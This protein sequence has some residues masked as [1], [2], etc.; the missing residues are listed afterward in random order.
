MTHHKFQWLLFSL[1]LLLAVTL[2]F[3]TVMYFLLEGPDA[4]WISPAIAFSDRSGE[5]VEHSLLGEV[6]DAFFQAF[7]Q[8]ASVAFAIAAAWLVLQT[9]PWSPKEPSDLQR[10]RSRWW[11]FLTLSFV[12]TAIA[13]AL[14][15]YA[16]QADLV[17]YVWLLVSGFIALCTTVFV[18]WGGLALAAHR[19]HKFAIP[20]G[21]GWLP[22]SPR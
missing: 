2:L 10:A 21:R 7:A 5:A 3:I 6:A 19:N 9:Y 15:V 20:A 12:L 16:Q 8:A 14:P 18:F 17:S 22:I 13:S 11:L 1:V 4:S